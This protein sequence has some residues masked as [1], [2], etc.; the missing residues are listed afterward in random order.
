MEPGLYIVGTPIGHLQDI[1]LRALDTLRQ[2]DLVVAEDTRHTR[3]LL[4]RHG[5]PARLFSCH[6]FNEA[7]RTDAILDRIRAG[8]A[9]A[10]VTDSGMP[11]VSDPGSRVVA[12]CRAAGLPA[13]CVPGPSAVTA[14]VALCGFGGAGF[15]F[16][17]FLPRKSGA[18]RRRL[19]ELAARHEPFVLFESPF[20]LLRLLE[21]LEAVAGARPVFL[22][23][24]LTKQF[25]ECRTGTPAELRAAFAGRAVKGEL[26]LVVA[27]AGRHDEPDDAPPDGPA[28]GKC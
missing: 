11:G 21:E 13:T 15:T 20:R 16:A 7:S 1:T 2:A 28:E 9:V 27:P 26:V 10:L 19:E 23:R 3:V 14:A 8:G 4:E 18:R 22:G 12:A 24:E 6:R 17:G 5:I 25:E